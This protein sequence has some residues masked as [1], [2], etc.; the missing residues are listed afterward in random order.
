MSQVTTTLLDEAHTRVVTEDVQC[1]CGS[2][3]NGVDP[4]PLSRGSWEV[5]ADVRHREACHALIRAGATGRVLA[6]GALKFVS[7]EYVTN[8]FR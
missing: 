5:M 1:A 3:S 8:M 4:P 7:V 6:S 2:T